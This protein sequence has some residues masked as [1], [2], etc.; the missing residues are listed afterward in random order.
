MLGEWPTPYFAVYA[1]TKAYV[2][3]LTKALANEVKD[4]GVTVTVLEPPATNTNF[5]PVAEALSSKSYNPDT[6]ANPAEVAKAGFEGLMAGKE[7]VLVGF[8]NKAFMAV[9]NVLPDTMVAEMNKKQSQ[10]AE[11]DDNN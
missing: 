1:A 6:L 2:A 4:S 7:K 5:F 10:P 8:G 11:N 3:S 9:T